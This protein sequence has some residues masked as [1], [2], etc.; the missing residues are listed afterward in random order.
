VDA[1]PQAALLLA[2]LLLALPLLRRAPEAS[3]CADPAERAARDGLSSEV[4]CAGGSALRGPAR[5]LFGLGLDPNTARASSLEVLPGIGPAR[6]AAIVAAR[7]ERRFASVA[8]LERVPGIGPRTRAG[9]APWLVVDPDAEAEC[10]AS[11]R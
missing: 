6:A 7:C 8:E 9:L 3:T 2:A 10:G 11:P 4:S 1:R 5:L